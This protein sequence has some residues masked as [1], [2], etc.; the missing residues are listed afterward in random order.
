MTIG[1][2]FESRRAPSPEGATAGSDPARLSPL[3]H[4]K[5]R[6]RATNGATKL[7]ELSRTEL[8]GDGLNKPEARAHISFQRYRTQEVAGSSPASSI[9]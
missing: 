8:A 5:V 3:R 7:S 4:A 9:A 1:P 6:D 2:W